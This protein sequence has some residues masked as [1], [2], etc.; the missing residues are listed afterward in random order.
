[1]KQIE[2]LYELYKQDIY[3]YLLSL[4][5]NPTLS[6]DLLSETFVQA[7][8]SI[9]RFEGKSSI[10]TWLFSISRNLWLQHLRKDK[11]TV[12]YNDLLE[13]YVSDSLEKIVITKE[14]AQ[15]V[16]ELLSER[17][18]RTRRIVN[19]RVEGFSYSEIAFE[20]NLS[21]GSARV[22]DFRTKK[23]IRTILEEEEI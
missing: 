15:R 17:D 12:E 4:T 8:T 19:M 1:M 20:V 16:V 22:I 9:E 6:E 13:I 3:F 5:H 21:E 14:A 10:K 7:I 18:E 11:P 2:K 23:W